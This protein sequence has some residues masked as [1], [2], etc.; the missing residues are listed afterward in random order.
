[1]GGRGEHIGVS[2]RQEI[3]HGWP[4]GGGKEG[5]GPSCVALLGEGK[6][7]LQK[8]RCRRKIVHF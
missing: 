7:S 5:S 3:A 4:K 2:E 8:A 6:D 1:M